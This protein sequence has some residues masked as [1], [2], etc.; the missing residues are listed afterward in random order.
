MNLFDRFV[1][2]VP[3]LGFNHSSALRDVGESTTHVPYLCLKIPPFVN[4]I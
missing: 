4:R 3:S 1:C 2:N